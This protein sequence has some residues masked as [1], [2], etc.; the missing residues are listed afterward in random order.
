M[1]KKILFFFNS[2]DDF[3]ASRLSLVSAI[4]QAGFAVFIAMPN[5]EN[6]VLSEY[7]E[8]TF[9]EL[10]LDRQSIGLWSQV[11]TFLSIKNIIKIVNPDLVFLFRV[12]IIFLGALVTRIKKIPTF[13]VFTGLGYVFSNSSLK[14]KLIRYILIRFYKFILPKKEKSVIFQNPDDKNVFIQLGI[15]KE[16][17]GH[18]ILG[19]GVDMNKFYYSVEPEQV[20]LK[21]LLLSRLLWDKGIQEYV[22][23]AKILKNKGINAEFLLVGNT[24]N[25]AA[26]SVS[27]EQ[28]IQWQQQKI[29]KWIKGIPSIEVPKLISSVNIV[30]LPSYSEG[31]PRVL[32]EAASVGRA[33]VTTDVPGCREVVKNNGILVPAKDTL[34]LAEGLE[35]LIKNPDLRISMGKKSRQVA[36]EYFDKD[37]IIQ[38][39]LDLIKKF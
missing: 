35:K 6:I 5:L 27:E 33:L 30:C 3:K 11:Q 26:T 36:E 8:F 29:I 24:D 25:N 19:S 23:A 15:I 34:G 20:P 22:D 16:K 4:K 17:Q 13:C 1:G 39:Y 31:L 14:A 32:I 7:P 18:I 2:S 12:K 9:F 38:Q 37:K 28:L 21:I 10:T